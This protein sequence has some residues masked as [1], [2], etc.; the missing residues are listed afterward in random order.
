MLITGWL[1]ALFYPHY[2]VISNK[3]T[4][5]GTFCAGRN[6]KLVK[7]TMLSSPND[8]IGQLH[9]LMNSRLYNMMQSRTMTTWYDT[10]HVVRLGFFWDRLGSLGIVWAKQNQQIIHISPQH[11]W[12][13][14]PHIN[15]QL[16]SLFKILLSFHLILVGRDSPFLD[17]YNPQD[18]G[19]IPNH[20]QPT[21]V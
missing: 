20:H 2:W 17:S 19:I 13:S 4:I 14:H 9:T 10:G 1:M 18:T 3:P 12:I 7:L 15:C 8:D 21:G 11:V 5:P 16:G 6:S